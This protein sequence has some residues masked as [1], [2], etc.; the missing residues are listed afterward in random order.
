VKTYE[1][2][3]F[4]ELCRVDTGKHPMDSGGESGRHWQ[5]PP[6]PKDAPLFE[7]DGSD[8]FINTGVWLDE[9]FVIRTEL[10]EEFFA[11]GYVCILDWLEAQGYGEAVQRKQL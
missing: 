10:L 8:L 1:A 5:K 11:S 2:K 9:N 3:N 7:T 4:K 6:I